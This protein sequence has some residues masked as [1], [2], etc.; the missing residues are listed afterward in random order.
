MPALPVPKIKVSIELSRSGYLIVTKAAAGSSVIDIERI[1]KENQLTND[2]LNQAR[3]RLNWYKRRDENKIKT[4]S[5]RNAFESRIYSFRSWLRE[6]ENEPYVEEATREE[7]IEYLN[8]REEWLYEDGAN[9]N[10]TTYENMEKNLTKQYETFDAR[11]SEHS[12]REK[13][14]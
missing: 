10:H 11:K 6:D 13:V 3:Q 2:Q 7:L 4:D 14:K 1:R 9:Q 5:A 12:M 8:D